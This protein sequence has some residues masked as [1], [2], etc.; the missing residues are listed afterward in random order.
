MLFCSVGHGLDF[1][2]QH[3]QSESH[4]MP[5]QPLGCGTR[6]TGILVDLPFEGKPLIQKSISLSSTLNTVQCIPFTK[7]PKNGPKNSL[8]SKQ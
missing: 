3:I 8:K 1:W 4:V 6:Y 5:S 7:V 2:T